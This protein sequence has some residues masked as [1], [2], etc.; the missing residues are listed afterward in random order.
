M[1]DSAGGG[2]TMGTLLAI[3]DS[4][5]LPPPAGAIVI[6][7]WVDLTHSMPS[8]I[9]SSTDKIDYLTDKSSIFP[10]SPEWE[11]FE[12]KAIELSEKIRSNVDDKPKFWHES[13]ECENRL[14]LYVSNEGIAIPYASSLL[15]ESLGD[16]PPILVVIYIF[17]ICIY[18]YIYFFSNVHVM[19]IT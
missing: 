9:D 6:S 18:T 4:K 10:S 15:A 5:S 7:P 14:H 17:Y 12:R 1:G 13:L 3:R 16:L 11:K 2:L 8:T 19:K